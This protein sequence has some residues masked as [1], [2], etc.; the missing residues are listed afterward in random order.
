MSYLRDLYRTPG[1]ARLDG[2]PDGSGDVNLHYEGD[3]NVLVHG[4]RRLESR[5]ADMDAAGVDMHVLTLTTPGVHVEEPQREAGLARMVNDDFAAYI[6]DYPGRFQAFAA[7]PLGQPEVAA[8]E[9]ERSCT[10]LGL[11][12]G[13]VFSNINGVYPD[14]QSFWDLYERADALKK[15]IFIHP[16]TPAHPQAFLDYRMVAVAGF[17]FDTTLAISRIVYSGLLERFPDLTFI[18]AHLG[19]TAPYIAERMDRAFVA[20]TE[21]REHISTPPSDLIKAHCYIDSVNWDPDALRL[22]LAFAGPGRV[23][24]GSDYPHQVGDMPRAVRALNEQI[25]DETTRAAVLGGN[26]AALLGISG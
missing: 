15:P 26:A 20:Y 21:C 24:L 6:R 16:T 7:L 25:S 5:L 4:H 2:D 14:H 23:M 17:L 3:Y 19:G 11:A 8:R 10:E 12:G 1:V 18:L 13:L 22:G 9:F